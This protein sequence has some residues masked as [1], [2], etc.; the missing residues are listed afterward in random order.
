MRVKLNALPQCVSGCGNVVII[1]SVWVSDGAGGAGKLNV[2]TVGLKQMVRAD[3]NKTFS[4]SSLSM[5]SPLLLLFCNCC[6]CCCI[7]IVCGCLSNVSFTVCFVTL[8]CS[9]IGDCYCYSL[10]VLLLI[11][12]RVFGL[13]WQK[14]PASCSLLTDNYDG[15]RRECYSSL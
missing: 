15:G 4:H 5:V 1:I 6:C 8:F 12:Y 10:V 13:T 7:L 3:R 11:D 14:F 9:L 2:M